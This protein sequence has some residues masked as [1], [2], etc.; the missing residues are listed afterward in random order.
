MPVYDIKGQYGMLSL[1]QELDPSSFWRQ[2]SSERY[3]G[4]IFVPLFEDLNDEK[5]EHTF[6][7]KDGAAAHTANSSM[8]AF[9]NIFGDQIISRPVW[10]IHPPN[11]MLCNDYLLRGLEDNT[12][13]THKT[14]YTQK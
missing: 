1:Q 5:K 4:Q 2:L 8:D 10:P 3:I 6:S 11:A 12:H 9:C 14:I 7:Q 13:K